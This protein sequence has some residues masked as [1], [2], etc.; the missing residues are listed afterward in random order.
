LEYDTQKSSEETWPESKVRLSYISATNTRKTLMI[1][2]NG[3]PRL[4]AVDTEASISL[5]G[6]SQ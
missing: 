2:V 6:K 4:C 1:E 5:I 3:N